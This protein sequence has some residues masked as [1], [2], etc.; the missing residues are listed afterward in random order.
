M[1]EKTFPWQIVEGV[2]LTT[3]TEQAT[4]RARLI[5]VLD[6]HDADQLVLTSATSLGWYLAGARTHVSL[7]APPIA[8]AIVT[9]DSDRVLTTDNESGRLIA[10][11]LPAGVDVRAVPWFEPLSVPMTSRTLTEDMVAAELRR[12]RVPLLPAET[13]QFRALGRESARL[14]TEISSIATP[15]QSELELAAV[16]TAGVVG[17]GAEPLVVLVGGASRARVRHPLPTRAPIGRR[18]LVVVCARR[19]GLIIN[20]SRTVVFGELDAVEIDAHR[21]ILAVEAAFLGATVPGRLL[22]AVFAEGCAAYGRNGFDPN[23]W[24]NHHQGG[25]AGYAGRDPRA[26]AETDDLVVSGQAFS[27]NPTGQGAK[28]E[29]TVLLTES[30][31]D[32]LTLDPAWPTIS[33]DGRERPGLLHR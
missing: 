12:L 29:D 5:E 3:E 22:S 17:L 4:K 32:V 14:L 25:V 20:I 16:V 19:H 11:E 1:G 27:W 24:R 7:A 33:V 28:V 2:V 15:E 18:A 9:R 23:E 26:T 6:R 30:G 13:A 21:R 10:E 8:C 31:L